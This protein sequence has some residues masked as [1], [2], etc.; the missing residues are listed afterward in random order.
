MTASAAYSPE[1]TRPWGYGAAAA[2]AG[3]GCGVLAA[4][5]ALLAST[6]APAA[7]LVVLFV[8]LLAIGVSIPLPPEPRGIGRAVRPTALVAP[9]SLVVG[10]AA[11]AAGRLIV[12]GHAPARLA[13]PVVLA[14]A[15]AAV[16]EEAWFRRVCFGLLAPAGPVVAIAGST[17][18]FAAVHVA[19]YGFWVVP[20]DLAA[21]ALL[22]WQRAV[23][24]SWAVPAA[25][26]VIANL[27]VIL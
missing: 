17:V 27:L 6:P 7:T 15:L 26:H 11:F 24:G 18:L 16:A 20:V 4:R 14:N 12:G 13:L 22:G 21:G 23:T 9:I 10:A 5:P 3:L 19:I 2:V 25:T 8:A 1:R